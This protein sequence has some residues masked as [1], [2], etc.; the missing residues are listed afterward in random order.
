MKITKQSAETYE[1]KRLGTV[2]LL[3]GIDLQTGEAIPLVRDRHSSKEYIEFLQLLDSKYSKEDKIRLVLDNLQVHTS[4]E[5][6]KYLASVPGR[7]EFCIHAEA[8]FLAKSC[9]RIFQQTH[10]SVVK[11]H[12]CKNE[13]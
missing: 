10:P 2:S 12:S 4:Q 11:R 1:Y 13:K 8:W 9:R 5:T 7:F 6:R 3:A